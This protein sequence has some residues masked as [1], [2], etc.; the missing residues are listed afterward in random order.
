M[1]DLNK[2]NAF[3]IGNG[4]SRANF[5]LDMLRPHGTTYGCNALYRDFHPDWLVSIDNGMIEEISSQKEF[6]LSRFIEP[7]E[8]EKWEP[9]ELYGLPEGSNTPRSNAGMN[10]M[11]EAIRHGHNQLIMIGFDFIVANEEIGTSNVYDGTRCYGK[12]TRASFQD[13]ARRMN[14]LNWFIDK[15]PDVEFVFCYPVIDGSVTIWQFMCERDVIGMTYQE[16]ED[17]LN[18]V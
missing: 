2:K 8:E 1:M 3:I 9:V 15:N 16:L 10:A 17:M 12:A 14:Y 13:Q 11:I 6:P 7:V 5:N 4:A 18:D